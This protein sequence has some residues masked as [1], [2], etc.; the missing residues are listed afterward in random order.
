MELLDLKKPLSECTQEELIA[1]LRERRA[2]RRIPAQ[3]KKASA[4]PKTT[5]AEKQIDLSTLLGSFSPAE[6]ITM[7]KGK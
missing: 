4:K 2:N 5:K 6:L 1:L 7:L 3:A